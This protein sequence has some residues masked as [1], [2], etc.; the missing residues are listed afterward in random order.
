M[1]IPNR[2]VAQDCASRNAEIRAMG[3][4]QLICAQP[5]NEFDCTR[6]WLGKLVQL[7]ALKTDRQ[8]IA[9]ALTLN[10][11]QQRGFRY[12][13][14]RVRNWSD[15]ESRNGGS[16]VR[17]GTEIEPAR[18]LSATVQSRHLCRGARG[19]RVLRQKRVSKTASDG[20]GIAGGQAG[21]SELQLIRT[22]CCDQS[23]ERARVV[24]LRVS[25]LVE[26]VY[27]E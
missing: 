4:L 22:R 6:R 10:G 27:R 1:S 2:R 25:H 19:A 14:R 15:N 3:K 7:I 13:R 5:A 8:K 21:R 9:I 11:I 23:C 16:P 18:I 12:R 20:T 26:R 17:S 24:T